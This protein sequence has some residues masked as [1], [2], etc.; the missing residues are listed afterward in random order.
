MTRTLLL[1]FT[2]FLLS[3]S[4]GIACAMVLSG[5]LPPEQAYR[6]GQACAF[7]ALVVLYL[8]DFEGIW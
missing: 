6:V 3:C 4:F 1:L 8:T 7:G 2:A 5:L